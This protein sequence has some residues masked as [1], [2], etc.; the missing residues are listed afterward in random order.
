MP[1]SDAPKRPDPDALL[2]Q[3]NEDA[4]AA[5]RGKLRVYFG[6]S[7][8]VGKT[9]AYLVPTLLSGARTLLSTATSIA[10][11]DFSSVLAVLPAG[12]A[13]MG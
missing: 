1:P 8:G 11:G 12:L 2:A 10:L 6:A 9:Y 5:T 13:Q 4:I 3:I 7:A